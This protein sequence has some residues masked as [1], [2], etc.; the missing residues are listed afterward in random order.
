MLLLVTLS[1][2]KALSV[3][4]GIMMRSSTTAPPIMM[5]GSSAETVEKPS[6]PMVALSDGYSKLMT[7]HYLP[8]AFAQ[9]AVLASGA[10]IATQ[11]MEHS[12]AAP[13]NPL[14]NMF[15]PVMQSFH[16]VAPPSPVLD[17][18]H[19]AYRTRER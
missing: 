4:S 18:H 19:G 3:S 8:M 5:A 12:I 14:L 13:A 7:Q 2:A 10:D 15:M 17:V 11:V 1:G 9:A 6:N 16:M